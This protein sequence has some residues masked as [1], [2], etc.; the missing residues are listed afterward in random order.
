MK[1]LTF[2]L[3]MGVL[4]FIAGFALRSGIESAWY[5][6]PSSA[7]GAAAAVL[8][9]LAVALAIFISEIESE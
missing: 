3:T 8:M 2:G 5:R 4:A 9:A 6:Q 7:S 1:K